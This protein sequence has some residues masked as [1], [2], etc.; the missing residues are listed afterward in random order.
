MT[1]PSEHDARRRPDLPRRSRF[2]LQRV[3][4]RGWGI[5]LLDD[6]GQPVMT[7]LGFATPDLA[8]VEL[9]RIIDAAREPR[10]M[11]LSGVRPPRP[12]E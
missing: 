12:G 7:R 9:Q 1:A 6:A 4:G 5:E 3:A 8:L 2:V 11:M 10:V